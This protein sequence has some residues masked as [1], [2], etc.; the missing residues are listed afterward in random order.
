MLRRSALVLALAVGPSLAPGSAEA[1]NG[2]R[3]RTPAVFT[4]VPCVTT[5]TRGEVMH[6][7]YAVPYDDTELTADELPD[8][9]RHQW[10][11]FSQQRFDFGFPTWVSQADLDRATDNGDV[12]RP[13]GPEDVLESSTRWPASTWVRITPD[14]ARL[15]ITAEQAAMGVDWDTAGVAPGTWLVAA[16]TWEPENNIW[17][18]RFGALRVEDA[19]DRDAAGPTVFLPR[20]DGLIATRGEPLE[21]VGCVEAPAGS[22]VTASWGTLEGIDEPQWVPFVED[23]PVES[24][25]LRLELVAPAEAGSTVKLRVEITDPSGRQYVAFTPTTIAVVGEAPPSDEDDGGG[26]EGCACGSG[27]GSDR[28]RSLGAL[29]GLGLLVGHGRRRRRPA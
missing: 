12:T 19:A 26:G 20:A 10:L 23:E 4:D 9:R 18:P 28:P 29:V 24:G 1:A 14:D 2:L 21:V 15:P 22:T 6:I 5:V 7:A 3:P 17:S 25:P 13:F 16:Y 8:S 27:R 11:A